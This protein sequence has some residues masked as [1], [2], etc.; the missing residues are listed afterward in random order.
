MNKKRKSIFRRI[1]AC[2]LSAMLLVSTGCGR[3]EGRG[4]NKRYKVAVIGKQKLAYWDDVEKGAMDAGEEIGIDVIYSVANGDNDFS[5]Q[6]GDIKSAMGANVDAIVIAPNSETELNDTL[7]EAEKRGIKII[8]INSNAEYKPIT[9]VFSSDYQSGALAARNIV[10]K[11]EKDKTDFSRLGKV[12]VIGHTSSTAE[13]RIGGFV[14]TLATLVVSKSAAQLMTQPADENIEDAAEGAGE[15]AAAEGAGAPA[16]AMGY[17][18]PMAAARMEEFKKSVINGERCFEREQTKQEAKKLLGSDGNGI[19]LMFAT[20]TVTTL[21]ICDAIDELHLKDKVTVVGF[22]SD[23][24]ELDFI[25]TD[26]LDAT[27]VQNPYVLGYIGV[28]TAKKLLADGKN[29][30]NEI[31]I[32]AT[33]IDK[34]NLSDDYSQLVIYPTERKGGRDNG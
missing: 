9:R 33:Y 17:G 24:E 15:A 2:A 12:A 26:V 20:N 31:D 14:D 4:D 3:P 8:F 6:D 7:A 30:P 13:E 21:G 27:I 11:L 32:G 23:E 10:K 34:S 19:T 5:T 1:T 16:A 18:D 22:N 29:T 28:R 25:K